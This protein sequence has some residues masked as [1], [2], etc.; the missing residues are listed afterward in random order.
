M[1]EE[2]LKESFVQHSAMETM[3]GNTTSRSLQPL[4]NQGSQEQLL[5]K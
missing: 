3:P 4:P 1:T 5:P 2:R